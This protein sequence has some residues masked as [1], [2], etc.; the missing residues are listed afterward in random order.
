MQMVVR[1]LVGDDLVIKDV[2]FHAD[3]YYRISSARV[4]V[5]SVAEAP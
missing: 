2:A 3:P 4:S 5:S 1:Q